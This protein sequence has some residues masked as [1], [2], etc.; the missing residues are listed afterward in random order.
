M[1][2]PSISTTATPQKED[3]FDCLAVE[4]APTDNILTAE[5]AMVGEAPGEIEVLKNE[6]FVGPTGSQLNRICAA[7][8]LARYKIYLTNAC[9]AKFPKNNTAVLWTD[10]GYR[11]PDWS[12]LQAALIDELAQFPGKVIL[13]L[14]AT[15]MRLLLD[16]PKFDSITKYRGSFYHAEDFP[17]LKDKLAGKIIGLSY[18]P[19]FT[20]PYGQPIHFYTMI[21]DFTKALRIIEAPELLV[22][23]VEIKI[24]PSF[25]EIMQF[26]ALIKTKEYVA[27]DIEATPEFITCYS[28]AVYHDNKILSMSVPLMNNQGNYWATAEEIKIW[29]GLAEILNDEAIGKICQNGMF[30]IMFTFR[31]MMIKTDNF[32]FD[33]MLAQHICYTELPKG[34]D[35]LTSTYTYYP[36]YKDEGKQSHLKAI[37][38][39]P[40][41]WTYNAK[42]SAY[43]L[44]ITEKLLEELSEFDSMDAMDYTMNLHKPLMEMEFN[45]IL[46]DQ[47]GISKR[48]KALERILRL[49]QYKLNKLTGKELNQG[50]SKQMIAY[51]YGLCMIKPYV[52]RKTGAISCDAVAMH[53]IAKKGIKGSEE[54]R[55]IIKMRGYQKLLSTYFNVTVDEDDKIRCN[56]KITGTVSGRIATEKTY[57]GTGTNL[58]NQPYMF[59]YYLIADPDWIMCECDLA[60]AEAHVVAYLTQDANMI[61]SFE[62]G[63]D[64][65]SFN[66]SKIFGVPIEEVIYEAK[67]KKADQKSTMRYMGKKVV[68]ASNYSMG[69]QTFSDNLA[70]EEVFMSQS[71]C[72]RL[73]DNY[74]DR[75]P[76]LKRWHRS[77]EEEVQKNRVLYNL[78]GRPRRFLGEMNAAL[79]RNAYSYKPQSTVAELLNRGMIK[80][81]NDPRLGKDGFDIR[82]MTTVHD[83]FVF[84]FHKSQ[85]PNLPQILLII[86]DHLTHTFTYKGKSFTIG[87]DAKIG[88]QWAGNTAEISKFTQEECDK[89]IEKIGF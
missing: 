35:Y 48:K 80:V 66:A 20:L 43:L 18:H 47:K 72:K 64:V 87:L 49:L 59:K 3:S 46:T 37:K 17:H 81:V 75:F 70:K 56:H 74:S 79:F 26:Y 11:H 85:I 54:A 88:T 62:S 42:D 6:P 30:D 61:Q 25:E 21:A 14:G 28:L 5:I 29:I 22:D 58:Q 86:K 41:Y 82:C 31:T 8:R 19:S 10:K 84:R 13:L 51:F 7:V 77:I 65:H 36:Y 16:E 32:Y 50:S 4:C 52:N 24:K 71:E 89:A 44:P 57:Q 39:W 83:S 1:I 23:N 2:I 9:K 78:F 34:L 63:I 73:L 53:R 68:H 45:G 55:I 33:T 67:N 15:P 27:F 40:Q 76:G 69:P 12:K 38:N 60:K